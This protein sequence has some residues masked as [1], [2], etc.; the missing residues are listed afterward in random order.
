MM[1]MCNAATHYI[2]T[3]YLESNSKKKFDLILK[4]KYPG[5]KTPLGLA[6]KDNVLSFIGEQQRE[7]YY[8]NEKLPASS[9][10]IESVFGKQKYIDGDQSGN[11]FTGLVLSIGAIV[12]TISDDLIK[13]AMTKIKTKDIF[14]WYKKHIKKSV[15]AERIRAFSSIKGEQK[16]DQ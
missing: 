16:S 12:S 11:G 3:E 15:Q 13:N 7:C 10:V 2:R 1:D 5:I 8:Q 14:K 9:E 6:M 4:E